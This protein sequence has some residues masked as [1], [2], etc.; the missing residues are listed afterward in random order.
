MAT[1]VLREVRHNDMSQ[2]HLHA[3]L[4]DMTLM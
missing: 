1:Y 3:N 4:Q 2:D